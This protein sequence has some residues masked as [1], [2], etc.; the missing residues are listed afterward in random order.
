M[1]GAERQ[2]DNTFIW[3]QIAAF[4]DAYGEIKGR[5]L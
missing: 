4:A 2:N 1:T 5:A 3:E